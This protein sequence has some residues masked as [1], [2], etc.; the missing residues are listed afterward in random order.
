MNLDTFEQGQHWV[1]VAEQGIGVHGHPDTSFCSIRG[2]NGKVMADGF[3]LNGT[4]ALPNDIAE[5]LLRQSMQSG[6]VAHPCIL[7]DL[8]VST[9]AFEQAASRLGIPVRSATP[10]EAARIRLWSSNV[11]ARQ[12]AEIARRDAGEGEEDQDSWGEDDLEGNLGMFHG[13]DEV[14][15]EVCARLG[16]LAENWDGQENREHLADVRALVAAINGQ[17][18]YCVSCAAK[19]LACTDLEA[20]VI[21][22]ATRH[23]RELLSLIE[24]FSTGGS[25]GGHTIAALC[26]SLYALSHSPLV[27]HEGRHCA[28]AVHLMYEATRRSVYHAA[29]EPGRAEAFQPNERDLLRSSR[30][31]LAAEDGGVVADVLNGIITE[32]PWEV[33]TAIRAFNDRVDEIASGVSSVTD[34]LAD[35]LRDTTAATRMA[36]GGEKVALMLERVGE[37]ARAIKNPF[38][39]IAAYFAEAT[40]DDIVYEYPEILLQMRIEDIN[41]RMEDEG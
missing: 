24:R 26:A 21:L 33:A 19:R 18:H 35:T 13:S 9:P 8:G 41:E 29:S 14:R 20:A 3:Q 38:D 25:L 7:V 39:E 4:A 17:N 16:A 10:E 1:V 12:R 2:V 31:L 28:G 37:E 34:A 22:G 40:E 5:A 11:V 23:P 6:P 32:D 30:L 27:K 36:P 15:D